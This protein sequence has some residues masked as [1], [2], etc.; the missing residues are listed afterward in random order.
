V[1]LGLLLLLMMLFRW[2]EH[3]NVYHPTRDLAVRPEDL[4]WRFE[5]VRLRT[6]DGLTLH[7]WFLPAGTASN[8]TG[9]VILFC[10]GNGGNISHRLPVYEVLLETGA[11]VLAFDYRGYGQS[12]GT[13]GEEGTYRDAEAALEWLVNRGFA[14]TQIIAF[15]ESLGGGVATELARRHRLGGLVLQSTFTSI[16]DVGAELFWWLP[17]RWLGS[18]AYDTHKKLPRVQSPVVIMH[19]REDRLVRFHHAEKNYAAAKEPKWLVELQGDHN[20]ALDDRA[21]L[22]AGV[23]R[24]VDRIAAVASPSP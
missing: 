17:V 9:A 6:S 12:E 4:G 22:R 23:Q 11:S 2:F 1:G 13:P 8:G 14:P 19:S 7:G 18:I 15:G 20:D 5:E 3:A 24:L 16:P 21:A 10:H